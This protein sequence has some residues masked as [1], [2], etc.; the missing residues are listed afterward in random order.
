MHTA[1]VI[2]FA[3]NRPWHTRQTLR[4]LSENYL[5]KETE[6][7][8][9]IDGP[10]LDDASNIAKIQ[11]VRELV[12]NQNWCRKLT[13]H[14]AEKNQGLANSVI[15]GISQ[16]LALHDRVIVLE[17]DMVVSPYFLQFM[18]EA[19]N[20]YEN[21][22]RVISIHGYSLPIDYS[23]SVYF[24]KGADCWGWAT[25]KR[26][27]DLFNADSRQLMR[28]LKESKRLY[29]FDLEGSYDYSGMLQRQI[30]GIID[31]W[32]IRW[33]AS[34]F[35]RDKLTLYPGKS[36]V[37]NIG[38]DGSGT[39]GQND[40]QMGTKASQEKIELENIPIEEST[41]A[42]Q[43]I[44]KHLLSHLNAKGRISRIFRRMMQ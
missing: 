1:P 16:T 13:V 38:M 32:A 25:W 2:L 34:A 6:L 12:H 9:Y 26:G 35:L 27:W 20:K 4:S 14:A 40:K 29:D 11:E 37:Q 36:L 18:N 31:S 22:D 28:E 19:L 44:I 42:R 41:E 39:H 43:L 15:S 24:L 30:D 33:Y 8:V 10:K 23:T 7:I 21:D 5:A 3:Y 17:D